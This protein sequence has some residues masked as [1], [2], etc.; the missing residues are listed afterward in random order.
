MTDRSNNKQFDA[1]DPARFEAELASGTDSELKEAEH[2]LRLDRAKTIAKIL[3]GISIAGFVWGWLSPRSNQVMIVLLA[4]PP[5]IA[6]G[7]LAR[8]KGLYHMGGL[9]GDRR[10]S[11]GPAFLGCGLILFLC[12]FRDI[13]IYPLYWMTALTSAILVGSILTLV[14][15]R[16]DPRIREGTWALVW[17]AASLYAYGAITEADVLLDWSAP[18]TTEVVVLSKHS[19]SGRRS[20]TWY[21]HVEK[22]GPFLEP[23][24]VSV[25]STFYQSVSPGQTVC[26]E[27]HSGALNI[28]WYLVALCKPN[29]QRKP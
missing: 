10:P 28:P 18:K 7:L 29:D 1:N 14:V 25:P 5:L 23:N 12:A 6:T 2:S 9:R 11:L 15:A 13:N 8:S 24:N 22:W 27:L 3:N 21:L 19:S 20:I 16:A 17:V 4:G 26:I